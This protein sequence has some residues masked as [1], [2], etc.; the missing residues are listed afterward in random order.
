MA[1]IDAVLYTSKILKNGE[2]PIMIRL[3]KDRKPKYISTGESCSKTLW[4]EKKNLP[5]KKHPLSK[6]IIIKIE[7]VKIEAKR[8]LH[9]FEEEA[10]DFSSEQFTK[11]LKNQSRKTT[12]IQF[13]EE[14]IADLIKA[15]KIGNSEVYNSLRLA[16]RLFR[17]EKDFAFSELDGSFLRKL[18]QHFRERG[19]KETSMSVYFRTLRALYN[20]A[21]VEDYAKKEFDPFKDF[22]ISKFDTKTKKR[23]IKKNEIMKIANLTIEQGSRLYDSQK[24]FMFSYYCYGINICDIAELEW[25]NL[26]SLGLIDYQRNKTNQQ[27]MIQLLPPAKEILD[28]YR[29]FS[30]G[31]Y[32]FPYL[33]ETKHITETQIKNRVKKI[34]KQINADLK[35]MA[36]MAGIEAHLTTYVARHSFATILKRN[37]VDIAKISELLGHRDEKTTKIYLDDFE[38][39]E[40][41]EATLNLL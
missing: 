13:L 1:S 37:G 7:K 3:I 27:M 39:E 5:A 22:K 17:S 12:V 11:K 24:T 2:H 34:T 4:D 6:E 35:V 25:D 21:V 32:I 8:L 40:L 29:K 20:R 38:N 28:Y 31:K 23:A 30:V 26:S 36:E 15:Q 10:T 33:N 19:I 14:V 16:I 9:K 18:E 41:Y